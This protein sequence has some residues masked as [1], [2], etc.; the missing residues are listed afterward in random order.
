[1]GLTA[2]NSRTRGYQRIDTPNENSF[3]KLFDCAS[4]KVLRIVISKLAWSVHTR[5]DSDQFGH[6][7][8]GPHPQRHAAVRE[9]R[10][11]NLVY[12]EVRPLDVKR[13]RMQRGPAPVEV[14]SRPHVP[15]LYPVALQPLHHLANVSRRLSVTDMDDRGYHKNNVFLIPN[16]DPFISLSKKKHSLS[17]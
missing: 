2:N 5:G 17:I 9:C 10:R 1:L 7:V 11:A 13:V 8:L 12:L 15:R 3:R 14:L 16:K 4:Y 6:V